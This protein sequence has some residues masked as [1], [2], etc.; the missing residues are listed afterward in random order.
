MMNHTC[1]LK[2]GSQSSTTQF[3]L[4]PEFEHKPAN[5]APVSPSISPK[6]AETVPKLPELIPSFVDEYLPSVYEIEEYSFTF[7]LYFPISWVEFPAKQPKSEE[8]AK[9]KAGRPRKYIPRTGLGRELNEFELEL[10][11]DFYKG[12]A[13]QRERIVKKIRQLTHRNRKAPWVKFLIKMA[14]IPEFGIGWSPHSKK[15]D[16]LRSFISLPEMAKLLGK[17]VAQTKRYIA[18]AVEAGLLV[19]DHKRFYLGNGWFHM[20][21][22]WFLSVGVLCDEDNP[23]GAPEYTLKPRDPIPRNQLNEP[24]DK[25]LQN[26][27]LKKFAE[28]NEPHTLSNK[29]PYNI[30]RKEMDKL[31]SSRKEMDK[32]ESS[33]KEMDKLESS[34]KEMDKLESSRKEMNNE[35][36]HFKKS[37]D[38]SKQERW[39]AVKKHY[40]KQPYPTQNRIEYCLKNIEIA[41]VDHM[42]REVWISELVC[43]DPWKF[44]TQIDAV[45]K[46]LREDT[47]I[48]KPAIIAIAQRIRADRK[49]A[50]SMSPEQK[51]Q[52][53]KFD[54]AFSVA[55]QK[56]KDQHTTH[57]PRDPYGRSHTE[58]LPLGDLCV[59]FVQELGNSEL[60]DNQNLS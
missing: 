60:P 54:Q 35:E 47:H 10:T 30:P 56:T 14:T 53:E 6:R 43:Y 48:S 26:K 7:P 50:R 32:L 8:P 52:K 19:R 33:R 38:R 18:D 24:I 17:S 15:G 1:T 51:E 40:T 39:E 41:G 37:M 58:P 21:P 57:V 42:D 59:N 29:I 13:L 25:C 5:S 36:T 22:G 11:K 3:E 20:A 12:K 46:K 31:E 28:L 2:S 23:V 4:F 34:R 9:S 44:A 16:Y 49:S 55:E 27:D 45:Y